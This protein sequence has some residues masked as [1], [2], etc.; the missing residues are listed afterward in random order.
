MNDPQVAIAGWYGSPNLGDEA[1][2]ESILRQLATLPRPPRVV[3]LTTQPQVTARRYAH[4]PIRMR[5]VPRSV[6]SAETRR[7]LRESKLF[8]LGGG[9]LIQD[10]SSIYSLPPH[11]ALVWLARRVGLRVMWWGQGA[12]PLATRLGRTLARRMVR[13][14]TPGAISLRD[15]ESR[16]I[17]VKAGVQR[18]A[19][20]VTA[21]TVL[22]LPSAGEAELQALVR[23]K[24]LTLGNVNVAIC[25]RDLPRDVSGRGPSYLLPVTLRQKLDPVLASGSARRHRQKSERFYEAVAAAA[26][27]LAERYG[28]RITF[29][30]FWPGRDELEAEQ[31]VRRMNSPQAAQIMRGEAPADV[32]EALLGAMDMVIAVR[33]H[34]MILAAAQGVPALGFSYARKVVGFLSAVGLPGNAV[35]PLSVNREQL[36]AAVDQ[37]WAERTAARETIKQHVATLRQAAAEDLAVAGRLLYGAGK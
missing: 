32:V 37:L 27:H 28:A 6:W 16:Q 7:A 15:E 21:D 14:S 18:A 34:A 17:L 20:R 9:G 23:D 19:L 29:V 35:D 36:L 2:L 24:G 26:D 31:V 10:R 5:T 3:V 33:L 30:P 8:I 25:L 11:A 4:L 12:E 22:A 1:S 13:W